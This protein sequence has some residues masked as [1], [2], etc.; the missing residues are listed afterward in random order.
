MCRVPYLH[1]DGGSCNLVP[2]CKVSMWAALNEITYTWLRDIFS[3]LDRPWGPEDLRTKSGG[4]DLM[5][6]LKPSGLVPC[7]GRCYWCLSHIQRPLQ[8]PLKCPSISF[9]SFSLWLSRKKGSS[10]SLQGRANS[11]LAHSSLPM[12]GASCGWMFR[13]WHSPG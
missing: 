8:V 10:P 5:Q 6:V 11:K 3:A 7:G 13:D 9:S 1:V 12:S 4:E 2:I